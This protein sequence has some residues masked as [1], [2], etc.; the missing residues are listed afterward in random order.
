[1]NKEL[2]LKRAAAEETGADIARL[3]VRVRKIDRKRQI[4]WGE[5]YAPFIID[6]HGDMMEPEDV[7]HLCHDF[8]KLGL[9]DRIDFMHNNEAVPGAY[10]VE[11]F[12][13]RGH[14]EYNEGAWVV[15]TYVPDLDTWKKIESGE[16]AGY[17]M[18]ILTRKVPA[19]VELEIQNMVFG[20]TEEHEDGHRHA[21]FVKV[22][23]DG[24]VIGGTTSEENGH[25]HEI[26][27][28]TA[29]EKADK[30]AHRYFLP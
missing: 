14:P 25:T 24:Q 9:H 3:H 6:T 29:T 8:A 13:A 4:V 16:I 15:A 22:N 10:A 21:F 2:P 11:S 20:F 19:L 23:D 12:I 28:G 17:S 26:N 27:M 5:V 7:E 18:E 1:M 30:H